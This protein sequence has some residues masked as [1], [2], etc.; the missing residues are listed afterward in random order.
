MEN[1]GDSI[2]RAVASAYECLEGGSSLLWF[3]AKKW[4]WWNGQALPCPALFLV[5]WLGP[6]MHERLA[7][8]DTGYCNGPDI[9][10]C[11][12]LSETRHHRAIP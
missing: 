4:E 3:G 10:Q 12:Y 8:H 9:T 7:I 2:D 6:A 1:S 5:H 11:V